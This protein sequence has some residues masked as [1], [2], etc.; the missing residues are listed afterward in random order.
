MR[1]SWQKV[2]SILVVGV[3][4][5]LLACGSSTEPL[6]NSVAGSYI[7]IV[8]VTV[9]TSGQTSEIQ[10]GST[11]LLNLNPDGTTSGHLHLAA[12]GARPV[13]DVDMGGSWV[14]TGTTITISQGVD[15]F[16]RNTSFE[17]SPDPTSGWDLAGTTTFGGNQVQIILT[18]A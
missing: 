1:H 18:P 8:W 4:M 14:Q 5:A 10:A 12:T 15:T 16:V 3:G 17:I 6:G 9:G 13:S 11:L 7:P 2:R